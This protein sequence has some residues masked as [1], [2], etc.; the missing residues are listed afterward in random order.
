MQDP[1][2]FDRPR[3]YISHNKQGG[4]VAKNTEENE[5]LMDEYLGKIS[6]MAGP[7]LLNE[8]LHEHASDLY[9]FR[10]MHAEWDNETNI[11]NL[12][13]EYLR[14]MMRSFRHYLPFSGDGKWPVEPGNMNS[15]KS[16]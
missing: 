12:P 13:A 15:W 2:F 7:G 14:A 1:S 6:A 4:P 8:V 3:P 5:R 11:K 10:V 9:D 16:C